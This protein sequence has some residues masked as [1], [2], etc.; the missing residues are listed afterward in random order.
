[1]RQGDPVAGIAEPLDEAPEDGVL[2]LRPR[3]PLHPRLVAAR[4]PPHIASIGAR[5]L[6]R[7]PVVTC[8]A[9]RR[10]LFIGCIGTEAGDR[11]LMG[12]EQG[13]GLLDMFGRLSK[14]PTS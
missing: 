5:P 12:G 1:M 7:R 3:A 2:L 10:E 14:P 8:T 6:V 9:G 4:R 11:M 13:A